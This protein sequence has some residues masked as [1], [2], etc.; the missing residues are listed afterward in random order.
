LLNL[1]NVFF[2]LNFVFSIPFLLSYYVLL[3]LFYYFTLYRI[4][5]ELYISMFVYFSF[6]C[7]ITFFINYAYWH[8]YFPLHSF[9]ENPTIVLFFLIEIS[10]GIFLSKRNKIKNF[11]SLVHIGVTCCNVCLVYLQRSIF[12]ATQEF[13]QRNFTVDNFLLLQNFFYINF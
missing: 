7:F 3:C 4:A 12:W 6:L 8:L 11:T 1:P 5:L 13:V 9:T 10:S 2:I